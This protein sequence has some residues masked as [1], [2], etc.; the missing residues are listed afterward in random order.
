MVLGNSG[1]ANRFP[2]G[3][4][5]SSRPPVAL[6]LE[7]QHAEHGRG[8]REALERQRPQRLERRNV[9]DGRGET[10]RDEDLVGGAPTDDSTASRPSA[11][12]AGLTSWPA[13]GKALPR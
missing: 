4:S 12:R 6:A 1:K 3:P 13:R 11:P 2:T 9:I 5:E 7:R 8:P 10:L